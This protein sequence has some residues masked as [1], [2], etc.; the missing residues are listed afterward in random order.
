MRDPRRRVLVTGFGPYPG[1][2]ENVSGDLALALRRAAQARYAGLSIS[3]RV[4]PTDW[5]AGP[6]ALADSLAATNPDIALHFGVSKRAKGF[7][8]ESVGRNAAKAR[9]DVAGALPM[10]R[11]L[12]ADAPERLSEQVLAPRIA[13]RLGGS[14]LATLASL[15]P[16]AATPRCR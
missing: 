1:V 11:R 5:Q 16:A 15:A 8:I 12:V 7:L 6:R 2:P 13:E 9:I 10:R 14:C 4:L 3:A